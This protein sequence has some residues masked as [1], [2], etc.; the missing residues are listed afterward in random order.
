MKLLILLLLFVTLTTNAQTLFTGKTVITNHAYTVVNDL[1]EHSSE[2]ASILPYDYKKKEFVYNVRNKFIIL[3]QHIE[4]DGV[5][6]KVTAYRTRKDTLNTESGKSLIL[7]STTYSALVEGK[8]AMFYFEAPIE[9]G[10]L[11]IKRTKVIWMVFDPELN[12]AILLSHVAKQDKQSL[13]NNVNKFI[14]ERDE[15][16]KLKEFKKLNKQKDSKPSL[17]ISR[18]RKI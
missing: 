5:K 4:V 8:S 2:L 6:Y 11:K 16:K 14:Q 3:D 18:I 17:P 7:Y 15:L 10:K 13:L 1:V 9:N 12:T